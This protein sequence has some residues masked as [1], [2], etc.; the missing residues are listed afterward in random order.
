MAKTVE[1]SGPAQF[2]ARAKSRPEDDVWFTVDQVLCSGD[3]AKALIDH[4]SPDANTNPPGIVLFHDDGAGWRA[5]QLGSGFDCTDEVV[6]PSIAAE[7]QC[8]G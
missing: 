3:W 2:A 1:V 5:V 4:T 6:P 7:L 8:N